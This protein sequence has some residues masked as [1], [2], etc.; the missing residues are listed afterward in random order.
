MGEHGNRPKARKGWSAILKLLLS[1]AL[2]AGMLLLLGQLLVPVVTS[3]YDSYAEAAADSLFQRG[4]LPDIIPTS[5][6][7]I[8]TINDL[9]LNVSHGEFRYDSADTAAFLERLRPLPSRDALA[10]VDPERIAELEGNGY[11]AYEFAYG[12][13]ARGRTQYGFAWVFFVNE[14]KGH[15]LYEMGPERS[16]N[17]GVSAR[18]VN[19]RGK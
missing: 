14:N 19:I 16:G 9:D 10:A 6:T 11:R 13:S 17:G 5:A 3:K 15:V 8:V 2:A 7:D 12:D 1:G 18:G 4:W